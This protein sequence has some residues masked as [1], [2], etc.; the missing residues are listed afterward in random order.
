MTPSPVQAIDLARRGK[1]V[2]MRIVTDQGPQL[3]SLK[4]AHAAAMGLAIA[5]FAQQ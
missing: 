5:E 2:L 4:K 3:L 1:T